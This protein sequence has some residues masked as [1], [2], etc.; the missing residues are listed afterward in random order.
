M[1]WV[2]RNLIFLVGSIVALALMGGAGL[3]VSG[4]L[5]KNA[6]SRE[7]LNKAYTELK[8]LK[9]Q[10]PHPGDGARVDNIKAAK[11]QREELLGHVRA[12]GRTFQPIAAIPAGS[13]FTMLEFTEQL[14]EAIAQMQKSAAVGS[15]TLTPNYSF[16]FEA[17]KNKL[18]LAAGSLEPLAVQLGEVKALCEILFQGR[19][20]ALESLRRERVSVDDTGAT[21]GQSDYHDHQSVTNE[22]G[23]VTRYEVTFRC[24]TPELAAVLGG[25]ASSPR[26]FIVKGISVDP[27][28]GPATTVPTSAAPMPEA[29]LVPAPQPVA[30]QPQFQ[31]EGA[32]RFAPP[33]AAPRPATVYAPPAAA[34]KAPPILNE[35]LLRVTLVVELMKLRLPPAVASAPAAPMP[36]EGASPAA[37]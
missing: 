16:S 18:T 3:Y 34:R 8:R 28:G 7:E 20:N 25:F 11:G 10:R 12:S 32:E 22:L 27:A 37:P 4:K 13:G 29:M 9:E 6:V 36:G 23:V 21:A 2:K 31:G 14:R 17:Q 35:R 30:P 19:I 24:F 5:A 1:N 33:A 26:G 15:V